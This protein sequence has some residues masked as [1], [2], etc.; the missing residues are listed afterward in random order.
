[1]GECSGNYLTN[2]LTALTV[3]EAAFYVTTL[4]VAMVV[5][6]TCLTEYRQP[7]AVL[8]F[9]SPM[10]STYLQISSVRPP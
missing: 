4:K 8:M 6:S 7:Q 3:P 9:I 10:L 5:V 1:M 2:N